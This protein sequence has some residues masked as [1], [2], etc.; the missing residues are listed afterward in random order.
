MVK[1]FGYWG[2]VT[3]VS[4]TCHWLQ[5][6]SAARHYTAKSDDANMHA[7][8][9]KISGRLANKVTHFS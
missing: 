6:D 7:N 1:E 9:K 8:F 5:I 4:F 3:D 2:Y